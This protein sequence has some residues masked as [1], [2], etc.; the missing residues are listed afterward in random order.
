MTVCSTAHQLS[1]QP[2]IEEGDDLHINLGPI[3][4]TGG[5][6]AIRKKNSV[7]A[8]GPDNTPP[9]VMKVDT[10]IAANIMINL[11]QDAWDKVDCEQSL[12][13][14]GFAAYRSS[15]S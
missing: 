9:E 3:S 4:R 5:S 1:T 6:E 15:I 12:F 11:L 10:E 8:P 13:C 7:K 2:E 14:C